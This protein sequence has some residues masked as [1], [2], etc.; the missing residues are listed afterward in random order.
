MTGKQ[1]VAILGDMFEL[2][3]MAEE[4]HR[5]VGR[6]LDKY[7]FDKVYL[8]GSLMKAAH[9][10]VPTA[11]LYEDKAALADDLSKAPPRHSLVLIKASRGMGLET[12]VES[13]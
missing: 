10:I 13:I 2:E 9:E 3:E 8:C 7:K 11:T 1:K 6:L 5:Q 12:L 4:E